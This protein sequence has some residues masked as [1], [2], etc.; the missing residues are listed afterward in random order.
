MMTMLKNIAKL[1]AVLLIALQVVGC[2]PK[3]TTTPPL[4]GPSVP[5][6][7][8]EATYTRMR[9]KIAAFKDRTTLLGGVSD[10][11]TG[12]FYRSGSLLIAAPGSEITGVTGATTQA[13]GGP[14]SLSAVAVLGSPLVQT[15]PD[16]IA[17]FLSQSGRFEVMAGG[18]ECDVLLFGALT[19]VQGG[20]ATLD[21]RLISCFTKSDMASVTQQVKFTASGTE[22]T[23]NRDDLKA[24]VVKLVGELPK[25]SEMK[26]GQ[27][28]SRDGSYVTLNLGRNDKVMKGMK[29]FAVT[30]GDKVIDPKSGDMLGDE[31]FTGD[32][33]VFA[34]YNN[35]SRAWIVDEKNTK[36]KVGDWVI[37][38]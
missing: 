20:Q 38:K 1:G 34:V 3:V 37:F 22:I 32:L 9:V 10:L 4:L 12:P 15:L 27:I 25:P 17:G 23:A 8:L 19:G 18:D 28:L 36:T 6:R 30:Y 24:A 5:R 14:M 29:A 35:I 2:A 31:V 11:D 33:Y 26:K 21:M 16:A 13:P 7:S